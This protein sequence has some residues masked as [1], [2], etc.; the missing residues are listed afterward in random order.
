MWKNK[1]RSVGRLKMYENRI[2]FWKIISFSAQV[3]EFSI[4]DE[5]YYLLKSHKIA[6]GRARLT[7]NRLGVA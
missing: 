3:S 6:V 5:H 1:G 2:I 4:V 7:T